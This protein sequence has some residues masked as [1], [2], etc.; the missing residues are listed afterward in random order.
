MKKLVSFLVLTALVLS[1]LAIC[2]SAN[3]SPVG[4]IKVVTEA[5]VNVVDA[6]GN[7]V[8]NVDTS[9]A[10][11]TV[12]DTTKTA[13]VAPENMADLGEAYAEYKSYGT[14][15]V[16]LSDHGKTVVGEGK[17]ESVEITVNVPGIAAANAPAIYCFDSATQKYEVLE[18]KVNGT[19]VT[20]TATNISETVTY[21]VI[22]TGAITSPSTGVPTVAFVVLLVVALAGAAFAGKKIFAK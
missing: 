20:F 7:A 11:V 13:D 10:L 5:K 8:A 21:G 12:T 15:S 22:Y 18:C 3:G 4:E 17:L 14:I 2:V 1:S 9:V 6:E 16:E 19:E